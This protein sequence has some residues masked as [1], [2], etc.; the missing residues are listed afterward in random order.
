VSSEAVPVWPAG[1]TLVVFVN[2]MLQGWPEDSSPL[3]AATHPLRTGYVDTRGLSWAA[4]G[5]KAGA[6]RLLKVLAARGIRATFFTSGV[7]AERHPE[8]V[9]RI[10]AAGHSVQ[11]HGFYQNVLPLYLDEAQERDSIARCK[12]ILK[13]ATGRA[14]EGW[15]SPRATPSSRTASLLA[16][17]GFRWHADAFDA[18][19]PYVQKTG[20]GSI[21]AVPFGNDVNDQHLHIG[22]GNPV[23]AYSDTLAR[24][25]TRWYSRNQEPAC[26]D[27]TVHAHIFGRPIGA[28]EF[29]MALEIVQTAPFA[30]IVTQDELVRRSSQKG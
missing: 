28:A 20:N 5:P 14:P 25:L 17:A 8:L 11:C 19:L 10:A 7:I 27:V 12:D 2:V 3:G 21:V 6:P 16:R 22:M 9:A 15:L 30:W 26:L 1:K 23:Q 4:Y 18:D 29:E 13:K 24:A